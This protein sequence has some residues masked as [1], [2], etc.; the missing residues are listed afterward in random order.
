MSHPSDWVADYDR[1]LPRLS[2]KG[3]APDLFVPDGHRAIVSAAAHAQAMARRQEQAVVD[4]MARATRVPFPLTMVW[5]PETRQLEVRF[6][7]VIR[8]A[9]ITEE[10]LRG[11]RSMA[12]VA[13]RLLVLAEAGYCKTEALPVPGNID[14][15]E[16]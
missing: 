10:G 12:D 16:N 8:G 14:L 6:G 11:A 4:A 13:P 15:G 5:W 7:H 9:A 3:I 1:D 2:V